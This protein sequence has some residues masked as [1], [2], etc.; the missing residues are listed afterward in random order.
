MAA[1]LNFPL[2]QTTHLNTITKLLA[3]F[4]RAQL[5]HLPTPID[6]LT[7]L[8]N[9][10]R[11][12]RL[13]MKRD[14]CTGLALGGNKARKLEFYLG[15][16][17]QHGADTLLITGA[18]QSNYVR[19]AA[20][21]AAKLGMACHIQLEER[22]PDVD[23]IYRRSGNVLLDRILGASIH[24]YPQGEDEAG[25]DRCLEQIAQELRSQG[26]RPYIIYLSADHTPLGALGYVNAANEI[27]TQMEE[28]RLPIEHI[29][30]A[31]GSSLSHSGLLLGLR[32]L[33]SEIPVTGVC[34][35]RSAKLQ[36]ERV[37][38]CTQALE[39]LLKLTRPV[40]RPEDIGVYDGT[41]A[42]GYGRLNTQVI[43]AIQLLG[44]AEGILL[45]PVYT[46]KSMAGLLALTRA[47]HFDGANGV[48]F[49]HTGGIP[50]LFAYAPTLISQL[51]HSQT[52]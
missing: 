30:I 16:A 45:D 28:Q 32:A 19:M 24:S 14:D 4:P 8:S 26:K 52:N 12:P 9:K 38:Q 20:A 17:Q 46:G 6:E 25:A 49:V 22:V 1:F 15:E 50:A 2:N 51:D 7:N 43:E 18:V 5:A 33:R 27:L 40:V 47:G 13:F 21:A 23:E 41:F 31:S 39:H 35:R 34:V 11:G 44:R 3:P 36:F 42:P 29:V 10:V 37:S 48:L